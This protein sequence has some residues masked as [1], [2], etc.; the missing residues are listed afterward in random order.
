MAENLR[1]C[2]GCCLTS[3]AIYFPYIEAAAAE[4]QSAC[5]TAMF[6]RTIKSLFGIQSRRQLNV[7]KKL[8][9]TYCN[10][11]W[12]GKENQRPLQFDDIKQV[13]SDFMPNVYLRKDDQ[14]IFTVMI[15]TRV[16][17]NN[18]PI[19][20]IVHFY[21]HGKWNLQV[22][23]VK[24]KL[25]PLDI[26]DTF[27]LTD[28]SVRGVLTIASRLKVCHGKEKSG[29]VIVRTNVV[30]CV[31]TENFTT[32]IIVLRAQGCNRAT[33]F[34]ATGDWPTCRTCQMLKACHP[35]TCKSNQDIDLDD[36]DSTDMENIIKAVLPN[37]SPDMQL[38]IKEQ[39]KQLK[40]K[41]PTGHRWS[42]ELIRTCLTLW[43]RSPL[44]Y[45]D[46]L[47]TGM[48][49]L[50]S[51]SVLKLYKNDVQQGAGFNDKIFNWMRLEAERRN[52]PPAGYHGGIIMDEMSIDED[53][54]MVNC[55]KGVKLV[56]FVDQGEESENL[57]LLRTK[58]DQKD[59]AN[60]VLL[61]QFLGYTGFRFPF[62]H[63]ATHQATATDLH[64]HFWKA[65]S[66][67]Q[68]FGFHTDYTNLDG[69][70]TNRQFMK[71]H[72]PLN[73]PPSANNFLFTSPVNP[74]QQLLMIMDIKHTLKK[75]RNNILSSGPKGTRLLIVEGQQVTWSQWEDAYK[76]DRH[77]PA[78]IHNKL[79]HGHI[80]LDSASKMRNHL[81]EH[82]L[83]E[84]M[85]QLFLERKE[86]LG[87]NGIC[88]IKLLKQTSILIQIFH[89]ARTI[90]QPGDRRL[91]QLRDIHKWFKRWEENVHAEPNLTNKD[92]NRRL[93]SAETRED[94]ESS[95]LGF[96]TLVKHRLKVAPGTSINPSRLNSDV[97]ENQFC[98]QRGIFN[99]N[100]S[101]PSY[102][103]F[104][105][106]QS[107]MIMMQ[108]MVSPK[109]NAGTKKSIKHGGGAVPYCIAA[110]E[111]L[112][113]KKKKIP[114]CSTSIET[115]TTDAK[116]IIPPDT[117][118]CK[119]HLTSYART[120][121]LRI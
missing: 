109:G 89:D 76:W 32:G 58:S 60:H 103:T 81:A 105:T 3:E 5:N 42:E 74:T 34:H 37:A 69:A 101:N 8:Q 93:M 20:K 35:A 94:T 106:T 82:V 4:G 115:S 70:I 31:K 48:L 19:V 107:A 66:L 49:I 10:I 25:G 95:I 2:D 110:G 114:F 18:I 75:I 22:G 16:S 86:S 63:F 104:Q 80:F 30:E 29:D 102:N 11:E 45:Q 51:R 54:Q 43:M 13:V 59:M 88:C 67:L 91:K 7:H 72:F 84:N 47:D 15:D 113:K 121:S 85:L 28:T 53:L 87:D 100:N 50:P 90:N 117:R 56:G 96:V 21:S 1:V 65:V 41:G 73:Q 39:R 12:I 78:Q 62:A 61:L 46:L 40:A 23:E 14:D 119:K 36:L 17:S 83:D 55:G 112:V 116:H 118:N 57:Q 26:S 97:I 77:N 79:T 44:G 71:M 52:L 99:G 111:P 108:P 27:S 38:L 33:Q 98:Q 9:T 68:S 120:S 64:I 6:G 24:V 92:K